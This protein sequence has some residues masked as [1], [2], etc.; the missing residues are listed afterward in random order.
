ML[1]VRHCT[2]RV[3]TS[4]NVQQST[5]KGP[6]RY[7]SHVY[8]YTHSI[9][10]VEKNINIQGV[11]KIHPRLTDYKKCDFKFKKFRK[12]FHFDIQGVRV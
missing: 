7:I 11:H 1:S 8:E 3:N 6:I 9:S 4:N 12:R 10:K 2:L 5:E